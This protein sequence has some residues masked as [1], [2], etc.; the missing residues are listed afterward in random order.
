[1]KLQ[2]KHLSAPVLLSSYPVIFLFRVN[3]RILALPSL[4]LPLAVS[5]LLPVALYCLLRLMG[6]QS[7]IA[8]SNATLAALVPFF[9]YGPIFSSLLSV[10]IFPVEHRTMLP[11]MIV[12]A[13]YA[14]FF[15]AKLEPKRALHLQAGVRLVFGGL[16]AYNLAGSLGIEYQKAN[17][18][19]GESRETP[20][21]ST[22]LGRGTRPD[23]Y[24][25]V[26]D[27]FAGFDAMRE[28]WH[29]AG[30]DTFES[31]LEDMGFFV[32]NGS[33]S[34]STNTLVEMSER[35][36]YEPYDDTMDPLTY[37]D[38]IAHNRVMQY[39]D[40]L[41]YSTVAID[42]ARSPYFYAAKTAIAS[43][44]DLS[45][46]AD[47]RSGGGVRFDEFAS[48]VMGMTMLRP[49]SEADELYGPFASHGYAV[50]DSFST[51]SDLAEVPPPRF[52]YA[53]I[54]LPHSPWVFGEDGQ[55]T[56]P[57]CYHDWNCYLGSYIF[58]TRKL[59]EFVDELLSQADPEN[60]PVIILQSD[61]GA[62][63]IPYHQGGQG[64]L[65]DYPEK[66]ARYILN[67]LYLPEFDRSTLPDDLAPINTFP[68]V[69]DFYFGDDIPLR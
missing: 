11:L 62:R 38:A 67:A 21:A 57:K 6:R 48:M 60:P 47:S 19:S 64:L 54:M 40:A 36:N 1:M 28:Y 44:Y 65:P 35:L 14:A 3:A 29:Y 5:V 2:I 66:Y 9:L 17:A 31:Y 45:Y 43:D 51:L 37:Y 8:A 56:D 55:I 46:N 49:L 52:V 23:I 59:R 53:H 63:N 12:L 50:L 15:A 4:Y 22:N 39:L 61:H 41:G 33:R 16:V 68:L 32:A 20:R 13:G 27:E 18:S 26:L 24:Y 10:D 7:A 34:P 30:I 42:G 25:V 69:F 58:A